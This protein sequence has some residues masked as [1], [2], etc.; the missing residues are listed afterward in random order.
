M[1]AS[2]V[3]ADKRFVREIDA[4][5]RTDVRSLLVLPLI[6]PHQDKR[7]VVAMAAKIG[8][9][10]VGGSIA[11]TPEG[12]VAELISAVSLVCTHCREYMCVALQTWWR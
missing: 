12:S 7:G 1:Y 2:T 11:K 8:G 9:V 3:T 6:A 5:N 10:G 4:S